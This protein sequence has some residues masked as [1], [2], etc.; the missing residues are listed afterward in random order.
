MTKRKTNS[1]LNKKELPLFC[2]FSCIYAEFADPNSIGACRKELAVYC[3]L[4]K[5]YNNKHNKCFGAE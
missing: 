1:P 3:K 4:F 2:D 5:R